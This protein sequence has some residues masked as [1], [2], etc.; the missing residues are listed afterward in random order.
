MCNGRSDIGN[1]TSN[2]KTAHQSTGDTGQDYG[3]NAML[4]EIVLGESLDKFK[5]DPPCL[6]DGHAGQ[7]GWSSRR[8]AHP[9]CPRS[10]R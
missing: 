5:H 8:I 1:S 3:H 6:R 10:V 9:T 4:Q 2:H 7:F